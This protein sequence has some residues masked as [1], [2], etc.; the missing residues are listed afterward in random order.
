[1]E[2]SEVP[3]MDQAECTVTAMRI[4]AGCSNLPL[5]S[6]AV[7]HTCGKLHDI[8]MYDTNVQVSA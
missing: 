3:E 8:N 1:M 7:R 6:V 4:E 2:E 5:A